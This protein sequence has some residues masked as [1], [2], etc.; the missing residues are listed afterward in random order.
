M[1]TS[2][3]SLILGVLCCL[4]FIGAGGMWLVGPNRVE[5]GRYELESGVVVRLFIQA[6]WDAGD[7]L[8]YTV[9]KD[10]AEVVRE[11]YLTNHDRKSKLRIYTAT[12]A[13]KSVVGLWADTAEVL[14]LYHLPSGESWPRLRD[15]EVA[16]TPEVLENWYSRYQALRANSPSLPV[17][18]ITPTSG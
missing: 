8:Y 12:S 7:L 4:A 18:P 13:D 17:P 9:T 2:I 16:H 10:G 15:N 11:T 1:T 6:D 14:V 3:K 5:V